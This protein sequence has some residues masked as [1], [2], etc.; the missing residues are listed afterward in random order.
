V[1]QYSALVYGDV[2]DLKRLSKPDEVGILDET[3]AINFG[4]KL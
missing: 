1:I 2:D 4:L 3:F